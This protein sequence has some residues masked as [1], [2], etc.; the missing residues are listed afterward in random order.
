[1]TVYDLRPLREAAARLN[2]INDHRMNQVWSVI[3]RSWS[4]EIDHRLSVEEIKASLEGL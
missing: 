4:K 2:D 1:V 3:E